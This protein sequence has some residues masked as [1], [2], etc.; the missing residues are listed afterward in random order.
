MWAY[1]PVVAVVTHSS[2]WVVGLLVFLLVI[3]TLVAVVCAF[4]LV[5]TY[6]Y[7]D[8]LCEGAQRLADGDFSRLLPT[9][10]P[11]RLISLAKSINRVSRQHQSRLQAAV[12]HRNE[13][14]AVLASMA[15]GVLAVDLDER[16]I[17]LNAAAARLLNIDPQWAVH[18]S[19]QE[20]V[21]NTALQEIIVE[22]LVGQEPVR[23]Q[24]TVRGA[25]SSNGGPV[26]AMRVFDVQGTNLHAAGQRIGALI[27]L[28]DVTDLR[29]L[30]AVRR[31]FVANASHEM[32]TP[33]T[34]IKAAIETLLDTPASSPDEVNHFLKMI[35]RA[36]DRL[37]RLVEDLLTLARIERPDEQNRVEMTMTSLAKVIENA[38]DSCQIVAKQR[39]IKVD[40]QCD[41]TLK[42]QM[43]RLLF[44]QALLNLIDNAIKY[45]HKGTTVH[46]RGE[47]QNGQN[48]ISVTDEGLGIDPRHHKRIFERFYRPHEATDGAERGTGLGLAIV[49]H[50]TQIHGGTVRTLQSIPGK[51]STFAI[52]HCFA[53]D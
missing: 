6:R 1:Y 28:H 11:R 33:V 46:V 9:R 23:R 35:G 18:C 52:R 8:F 30:E 21:R 48:V 3:T 45:S 47:L 38:V 51:G 37:H 10:G 32:K 19:I 40:W 50:I 13:L 39:G 26:S 5:K 44:E 49:K 41:S 43:N 27:V 12:T 25:V 53:S 7:V 22:S 31:D 34:A 4:L 29:R 42:T 24:I 16:L 14:E 2:Q 17:K 20:V 15:E 36:A